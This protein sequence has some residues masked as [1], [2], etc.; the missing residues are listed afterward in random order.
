MGD[1]DGSRRPALIKS[2]T[3]KPSKLFSDRNTV[4]SKSALLH[5][6]FY[7]PLPSDHHHHH[8]HLQ[9]FMIRFLLPFIGILTAL[10][11]PYF[12][13]ENSPSLL[14]SLYHRIA[15]ETLATTASVPRA[16][17]TSAIISS[18][19]STASYS[20]AAA[21]HNTMSS[22]VRMASPLVIPAVGRHTAT[23]IFAHGL[24]DTGHGWADAVELWRER[25]RLDE[26]KFILPH[27]PA[28]P[29]SVVSADAR[30]TT[31]RLGEGSR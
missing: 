9:V 17:T 19:S 26:V 2:K 14:S 31:R 4:T 18:D 30:G 20:A 6:G 10:I 28:R 16:A 3:W 23:V 7:R 29:I 27:A 22:S 25:K 1:R 24:G 13:H 15:S 5:S 8:H 21:P 11:A 12:L